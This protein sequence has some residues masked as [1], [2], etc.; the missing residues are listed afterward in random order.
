QGGRTLVI[1]SGRGVEVGDGF[2][3]PQ[4]CGPA[5]ADVPDLAV[6]IDLCGQQPEPVSVQRRRGGLVVVPA[7]REDDQVGY[8]IRANRL[9]QVVHRLLVDIAVLV[10]DHAAGRRCSEGFGHV[11]VLSGCTQT[12]SRARSRSTRPPPWNAA[13]RL[14]EV[15]DE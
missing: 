2:V 5:Y 11:G 3:P 4:L 9:R 1:G 15:A 10:E 8:A 13:S 14:N 6:R 12:D 7:V